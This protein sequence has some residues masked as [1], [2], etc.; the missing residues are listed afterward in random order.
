LAPKKKKSA[1]KNPRKNEIKSLFL[2]SKNPYFSFGK[3]K[4]QYKQRN[5]SK[6]ES[7]IPI[8][9]LYP[10]APEFVRQKHSDQL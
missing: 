4:N 5:P 8:S 6:S 2:A 10:K 1:K 9:F 7:K 3:T